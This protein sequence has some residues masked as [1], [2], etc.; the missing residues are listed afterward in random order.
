M[1][2]YDS[3][4]II[5]DFHD[6]VKF[7]SIFLLSENAIFLNLCFLNSLFIVF[8]FLKRK[9]LYPMASHKVSYH[10]FV[11][12]PKLIIWHKFLKLNLTNLDQKIRCVLLKLQLLEA[13]LNHPMTTIES[14]HSN[15]SLIFKIIIKSWY[16]LQYKQVISE[17][18]DLLLLEFSAKLLW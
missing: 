14:W 6:D 7:D 8:N 12:G 15:L 2:I 5:N 1:L 4:I 9:T 10:L 11:F 13:I 17:S 3:F 18:H 16:F